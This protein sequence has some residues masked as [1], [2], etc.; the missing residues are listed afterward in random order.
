VLALVLVAVV[1]A[2]AT[3]VLGHLVALVALALSTTA[4]FAAAVLQL[5]AQWLAMADE[6]ALPPTVALTDLPPADT[7]TERLQ[8]L[9]DRYVSAVNSA[10]DEGDAERA[11]ELADTYADDALSVIAG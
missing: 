9:R 5:R 8:Q 2:A 1:L 7:T 11:R 4:L 10:L 3:A 6:P